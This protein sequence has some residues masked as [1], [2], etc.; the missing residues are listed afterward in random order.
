MYW[1]SRQQNIQPARNVPVKQT[2]RNHNQ[3]RFS[4]LTLSPSAHDSQHLLA[5]SS[6]WVGAANLTLRSGTAATRAFNAKAE[7]SEGEEEEG[8]WWEPLLLPSN[9]PHSSAQPHF[10]LASSPGFSL[11]FFI[12]PHRQHVGVCDIYPGPEGK[13]KFV[14]TCC[15]RTGSWHHAFYD[16]APAYRKWQRLPAVRASKWHATGERMLLIRNCRPACH[17]WHHNP[18]FREGESQK[19]C[20][21][22]L[23]PACQEEKGS[24]CQTRFTHVQRTLRVCSCAAMLPSFCVVWPTSKHTTL[25]FFFPSRNKLHGR[26]CL[27]YT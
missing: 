10:F 16:E 21:C 11:L 25:L 23:W 26:H 12:P 17:L 9:D 2:H 22:A 8:G 24:T 20:E 3:A 19:V 6:V 4:M 14:S 13:G 1:H 5:G 15:W 27:Q 7:E 18:H